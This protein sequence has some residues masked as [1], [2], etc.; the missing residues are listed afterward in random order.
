MKMKILP[1]RGEYYLLDQSFSGLFEETIFQM[2]SDKGKGIVVVET[3]DGNILLGPTA[4]DL[5]PETQ[6]TDTRTT[7]QGLKDVLENARRS[8]EGIPAGKFITNFSGIRARSSTDDFVI[9]E[10]PGAE[11]FFN[12]AGIE[13]PGLTSAPAIGEELARLVAQKLKAEPNE[14]FNPR[15]EEIKSFKEANE[16]ER[17]ALIAKDPAYGRIVCRCETITEAEVRQAV[18]R[19][20]GAR[21]LDAVKRRVRAGAGRCQSGFCCPRVTEILCEELELTPLEVTKFGKGSRMLA[22]R[23]GEGGKKHAQG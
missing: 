14:G 9:G 22:G 19:P 5:D 1:R 12:A 6:L 2:P 10:A 17:R 15:R 21:N 11:G 13:S 23:I 20:V 3:I 16:E 4:D 8:W 7:A 18:R